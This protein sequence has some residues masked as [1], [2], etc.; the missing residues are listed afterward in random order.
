[1]KRAILVI[2]AP[3]SGTS[4]IS[5][6][7]SRLGVNFGD[8]KRFVDAEQIKHN[9]IFFELQ[10]LN[11]INREIFSYFDKRWGEFNWLPLL[12]DFSESVISLFSDRIK[13]FVNDEFSGSDIIG[14]KDPRFCFTLPIWSATLENLGY[15]IDYVFTS[16]NPNSIFSSNLK[17]NKGSSPYNFRVTVESILSAASFLSDRSFV[18]VNYETLLSRPNLDV[19]LLCERLT[20]DS[21]LVDHACSVI[22]PDLSHSPSSSK[23][24]TFKYFEKIISDPIE[25]LAFE[26]E[27]YREAAYALTTDRDQQIQSLLTSHRPKRLSI[28]GLSNFIVRKLRHIFGI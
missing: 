7:L 9:P 8:P 28:L 11:E 4:A 14:L 18:I 26:Y 13:Q 3:R 22:S 23:K 16:R 20:L 1:M 15:K 12:S 5:H 24:S 2:G 17:V 19:E 27:R 21:S 25:E 6:V 10:E